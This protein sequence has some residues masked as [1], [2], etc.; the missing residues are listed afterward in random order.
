MVKSFLKGA[1]L[2]FLILIIGLEFSFLKSPKRA[3]S[4]TPCLY[5]EHCA[6]PNGSLGTHQC[7]G[8]IHPDG[9]CGYD[10]SIPPNCTECKLC[11]NNVC[12]VCEGSDWCP[13]DCGGGGSC[14]SS[15]NNCCPAQNSET[16]AP[17]TG[18]YIFYCQSLGCT[19]SGG[20]WA[21][22][23]DNSNSFYVRYASGKIENPCD[24]LSETDRQALNPGCQCWAWQIDWIDSSGQTR[25]WRMG[26]GQICQTSTPTPTPSPTPT[27]TP[28]PTSTPTPSPTPS[29]TPTPTPTAT[30]SPTQI[31]TP[32]PS[33][34]PTPGGEPTPTPTPTSQPT[35]TPT[36]TSTPTPPQVLGAQTPT[37][38]PKAGF[39]PNVFFLLGGIGTVFKLLSFLL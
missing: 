39:S 14:G 4:S 24:N 15:P 31:P 32:T 22:R 9:G 37:V 36:P 3:V 20:V 11:G 34:T 6:L 13:Q 29:P 25:G 17:I 19:L 33:P 28:T 1:V 35:A 23:C 18:S 27:P 5:C 8:S 10:P 16:S 12:D 26:N 7:Q 38:L 30:P 21:V 2:G